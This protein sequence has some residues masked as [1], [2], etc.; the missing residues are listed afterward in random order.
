MPTVPFR[1]N[2]YPSRPHLGHRHQNRGHRQQRPTCI[3]RALNS[4]GWF[5]GNHG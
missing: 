2:M 5:L 4:Q 3:V 1:Q